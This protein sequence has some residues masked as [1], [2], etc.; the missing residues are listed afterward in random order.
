MTVASLAPTRARARL[1]ALASA[2]LVGSLMWPGTARAHTDFDSSTPSD[3]EVV[4]GPLETVT[5]RFTTPATPVEPGF[6]V[7]DPSGTLRTP[8]SID[9]GD[10][11]TFVLRF[12]PPLTEGT[13][14]VRWKVRA[15][16]AHPIDGAFAFEVTVPAP[17]PPPTTATESLAAP[18]P[19]PPPANSIASS[20][21]DESHTAGVGTTQLADFLSADSTADDGTA[22]GRAGRVITFTGTIFGVGALAALMWVIRGR[23]AELRQLAAW[24]RIAGIVIATGGLLELAALH[25]GH[26]AAVWELFDSKVGFAALLKL[27]G[28]VAV[29]LGFHDRAGSVTAPPLALSAA[30]IT[31]LGPVSERSRDHAHRWT[32]TSAAVVGFTGYA[33]V[34]S[35]FWFDGH[36]VSR[37]PWLVHSVVNSI[38]L[39]AAAVWG[40]GVFA[41]AHVAWMRRRRSEAAGLAAMVIRFSSLAT[42]SLAAVIVAGL[43]MAALIVDTPGELFTTAWGRLLLAKTA[44][45][46]AAAAIGGFNHFRL[47]P[48]LERSPD[49]PA[50]AR[51]L[52]IS[53]TVESA[54]FA[55]IVV[56]TAWL[57]AAAT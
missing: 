16:D 22:V 26:P 23:R 14:G 9:E 1:G 51:D 4:E 36:T 24:V 49:D 45:V 21:A 7:L 28:G 15:G 30:A 32:P 2:V 17:A 5:V 10:G 41:M 44:V 25:A 40:G 42:A 31:D 6:E 46:A 13:H 27:V 29:W 55:V 8:T 18:T 3:Q 52:R 34:L 47:K 50:L 39:G 37:G 48:A 38:H 20:P 56:L 53:L 12:D 54:I 19:P 33:V 57:V 11:T 43:T 35:S